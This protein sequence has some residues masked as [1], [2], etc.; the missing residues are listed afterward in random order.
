[1]TTP[2]ILSNPHFSEKSAAVL[3]GMEIQLKK[4]GTIGELQ[5]WFSSH[6]P[7]LK[8]EFYKR[9]ADLTNRKTSKIQNAAVTF[10]EIGLLKEGSLNISDELTVGTLEKLLLDEY[11]LRAEVFR[12]SGEGLWLET[13]MTEDWSLSK[14]NEYGNEIMQ[15]SGKKAI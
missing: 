13:T 3:T 10:Q 7:F 4:T 5:T 15:L 12:N 14:Q 1:M 8:V 11:G 6:Y 2:I 9:T